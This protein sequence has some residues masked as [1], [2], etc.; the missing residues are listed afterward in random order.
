MASTRD[1]RRLTEAYRRSQVQMQARMVGEAKLLHPLLNV[2]ALDASTP[3]WLAAMESVAEAG[4]QREV[5]ESRR[6]LQAF[7]QAEIGKDPVVVDVAFPAEQV[8]DDLMIRGPIRT[9]ALIGEGVAPEKA[10]AESG[11]L[12]GAGLARGVLDIGRKL[13]SRSAA[14]TESELGR[15][16]KGRWRRVAD[17][18]P[19][20]FCAMLA[21]RGPVYSEESVQ[22]H[23]HDYCGCTVEPVYTD[24]EPTD[25]EREWRESYVQAGLRADTAEG[26]RVAPH[27]KDRESAS[28]DTILWR[29]RRNSPG[30]FHD[31]VYPELPV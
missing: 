20:A 5:A 10:I 19:C 4:Y 26:R 17:G 24:W 12:V 2:E 13:V 30:L 29:M 14:Q 21:G 22:F 23:T 11:R 6:Y 16:R 28:Q 15:G 31:G 25:L 3:T 18:Q 8:R 9:K 7:T 27:R 1:G